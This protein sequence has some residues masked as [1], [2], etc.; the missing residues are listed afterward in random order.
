MVNLPS[1]K[2]YLYSVYILALQWTN[3]EFCHLVAGIP[4]ENF[5]FHSIF[6]ANYGS[7]HNRISVSL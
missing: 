2:S 3:Q 1:I 7:R 4:H 6:F 5:M